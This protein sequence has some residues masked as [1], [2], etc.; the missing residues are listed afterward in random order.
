MPEIMMS[1]PE[2]R[3]YKNT[4]WPYFFI[5]CLLL[6]IIFTLSGCGDNEQTQRK[7]FI[8]FL[9]TRVLANGR[10]D[11]PQ[12]SEQQNKAFG[13][14]VKDY[15]VIAHF[16]QKMATELN[17]S[18]VPVFTSMN[19]LTSVNA[20]LEQRNDL[21]IMA[22]KSAQWQKDINAMRSQA[23][24]Q[25][26]TLKQPPDLAKVYDQAYNKAVSQPADVAEQ[27]FT[28]LPQVLKLIVVKADF[29]KDQGKKV[30][31][32]GNTLQFASQAQ[33][34]KYNAIQKQLVPLNAQL[35]ALSRQMQQ[36]MQ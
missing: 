15:A 20:L 9:Q 26:G 2:S 3:Q 14:Y 34:N 36:L 30:T 33:L 19:A 11:L 10:L 16:H 24:A 31:V 8:D 23:E 22:D 13:H 12:L 28:L 25:R 6:L 21:Q 29:I 27:L 7:A 18:L 35:M 5:P 1:K 32:T 4:L 17:S